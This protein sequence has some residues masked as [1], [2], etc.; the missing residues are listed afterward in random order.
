MRRIVLKAIFKKVSHLIVLAILLFSHETKAQSAK[1]IIEKMFLSISQTKSLT[2]S[3]VLTE[4]VEGEM[5]IAENKIKLNTTPF[6]S[7]I[8]LP[9]TGVEVLFVQGKN[10]NKALIKPN[11]F[12][13]INLNLDVQNSLLR[14]KQHHTIE[15][16]GFTY[17][18]EVFKHDMQKAG[19]SFESRISLKGTKKW[20]NYD[21]YVI[22]IENDD[23]Q[24]L[25]YTL[26]PEET[27]LSVAKKHKLSEYMILELNKEIAG[28]QTTKPGY[29]IK[30]PNYY[31][32]KSIL[33]IDKK[34][35]LPVLKA[36]FDDK[37]LFEKYEYKNLIKNPHLS[38]EEFTKEYSGYNF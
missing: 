35:F 4:R 38:E 23:F 12:P 14:N 29:T 37:G 7:Y 6:K 36:I 8:F 22:S 21:C 33:Y 26:K 15:E 30:I 9:N 32:K 25:N 10:Q 16:L 24:Y 5:H 2:Y 28:Y 27:I 19:S 18:G 13:Y 20:E 17:F 34:T 11:K 1:E 3:S 31:S